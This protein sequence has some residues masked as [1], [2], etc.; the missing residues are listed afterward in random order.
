MRANLLKSVAM[1]GFILLG[2]AALAQ[3]TDDQLV[4]Q[5]RPHA[6][7]LSRNGQSGAEFPHEQPAPSAQTDS[8]SEMRRSAQSE[9]IGKPEERRKS[10]EMRKPGQSESRVKVREGEHAVQRS[11]GDRSNE[12]KRRHPT[13]G[14][15]SGSH[16][17]IEG[18][19]RAGTG[20]TDIRR[21]RGI[22]PGE[23]SHVPGQVDSA[24]IDARERGRMREVLRREHFETDLDTGFS[25]I[26]GG[27]VPERIHFHRL[28]DEL[29]SLVPQYRG[30]EYILSEDRVVVV[31]PNSR[32]NRGCDRRQ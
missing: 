5:R 30:Y 32:K 17:A 12:P 16:S 4:K 29:I 31:D 26:V 10:D 11:E 9:E 2:S 22:Q 25:V 1:I 3:T 14:G 21:Q 18:Q 15:S 24:R 6:Q 28:P 19:G 7:E 20:E 23:Q 8:Q 27:I 13:A